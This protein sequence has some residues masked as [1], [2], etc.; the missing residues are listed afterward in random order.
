RF[1]LA[2]DGVRGRADYTGNGFAANGLRVRH[3]GRPGVLDLRAGGH[4]QSAANVFEAALETS[5][6]ADGLLARAPDL[7]WLAP[8]LEG[9]SDWRLALA[10]PR[11]GTGRLQ[12]RSDLVGTAIALPAP[13]DKSRDAALD[14]RVSLALPLDRG[15]VE[16]ALGERMALRARSGSGGTG[17]RVVL[18]AGSVDAAPPARGLVATGRADTLAPLEWIGLASGGGGSGGLPM[19]GI[20][21][22]ADR[23]L[24]LGGAFADTRLRV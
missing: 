11:N 20:D 6:D 16:V 13:V 1:D 18:G 21:V 12:L 9:R 2:F 17:V 24:L 4:V 7:A 8:H 19:R 3:E 14:T 23:L 15:D 22:T 5:M 10:V